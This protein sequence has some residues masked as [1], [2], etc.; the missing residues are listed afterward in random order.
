MTQPNSKYPLKTTSKD[1]SFSLDGTTVTNDCTSPNYRTC[2]LNKPLNTT[3]KT[4][5]VVEFVS[6]SNGW[7]RGVIGVARKGTF[8]TQHNFAAYHHMYGS[9]FHTNGHFY[10]SKTHIFKFLLLL[11]TI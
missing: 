5:L 1:I 2:F 9:G 4:K 11:Y 7:I 6:S 10:Y 8:E 3:K